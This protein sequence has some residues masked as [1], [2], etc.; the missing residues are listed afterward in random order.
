MNA[1][2]VEVA[3][4]HSH[5]LSPAADR[6]QKGLLTN[7]QPR[8]A[9]SLLSFSKWKN[10]VGFFSRLGPAEFDASEMP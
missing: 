8:I 7:S 6:R 10:P 2:A 1:A 3:L 9:S 5:R 4:L